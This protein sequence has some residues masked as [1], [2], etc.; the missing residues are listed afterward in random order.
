MPSQGLLPPTQANTS[1]LVD[2]AL[3]VF[4]LLLKEGNVPSIVKELEYHVFL[5]G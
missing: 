3:S 4:H 2:V 1:F 5:E